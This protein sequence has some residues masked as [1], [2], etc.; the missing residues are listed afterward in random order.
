MALPKLQTFT[1]GPTN[2]EKTNANQLITSPNG[3]FQNVTATTSEGSG[4]L[5][6]FLANPVVE[7]FKKK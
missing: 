6:L 3:G 2:S 4:G 5:L 1:I 7:N